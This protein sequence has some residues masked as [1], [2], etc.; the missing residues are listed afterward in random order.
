MKLSKVIIKNYVLFNTLCP[1][2]S[3]SVFGKNLNILATRILN[4][5]QL[6]HL[7]EFF[8]EGFFALYRGLFV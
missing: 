5:Y 8:I 7:L 6:L 1:L 4:Y 3:K 2:S